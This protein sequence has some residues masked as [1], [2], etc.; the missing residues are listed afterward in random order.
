MSIP[1]IENATKIHNK[2]TPK[3]TELKKSRSRLTIGAVF[4]FANSFALS[5][6][7]ATDIFVFLYI[8]IKNH[9]LAVLFC[10]PAKN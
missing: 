1:S 6:S 4:G 8:S 2:T 3:R 10:H 5:V 7:S 9:N